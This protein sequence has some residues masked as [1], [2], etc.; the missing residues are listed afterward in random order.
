MSSKDNNDV[1]SNDKGW[2]AEAV[3]V[4]GEV[5][6]FWGFKENHGRIWAFLYLSPNPISTSDIR[7][8]LKL[9]KGATSMLLNELEEWRVILQSKPSIGRE[10]TYV[11]NQNFIEMIV[12]VME[13]RESDM[14]DQVVS[15]L[16]YVQE[17]ASTSNAAQEQ[18]ESIQKMV[19]LAQMVRQIVSIGQ[20]LQSRNINKISML[21]KT[22][23]AML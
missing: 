21:L 17:K 9:S 2:F 1:V 11:A 5:I 4:V 16:N 23:D 6:G 18:I 3:A 13:R 7:K 15:R 22:I 19:D 8:T 14:L 12:R 10:R 20:K